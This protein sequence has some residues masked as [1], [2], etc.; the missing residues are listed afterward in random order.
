MR[1]RGSGHA[2][3]RSRSGRP[4]HLVPE[5]YLG[6]SR[7]VPLKPNRPTGP[8]PWR[9]GPVGLPFM[10]GRRVNRPDNALGRLP[11]GLSRRIHR[12]DHCPAGDH[13]ASAGCVRTYHKVDHLLSAFATSPGG[14]PR[15][16]SP[17][18]RTSL[19]KHTIH[20]VHS[21]RL[22]KFSAVWP[23]G[24]AWPCRGSVA[25]SAEDEG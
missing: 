4:P 5:M 23:G 2:W 15:A 7:N 9:Q 3:A 6:T 24:E 22:Q 10:T 17:L 19:T 25:R 16:P 20:H 21:Q 1:A 13:T 8:A 18:P 11:P 14:S 12:Y